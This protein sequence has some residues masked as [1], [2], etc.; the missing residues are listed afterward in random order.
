[1]SL[2]RIMGKPYPQRL[3]P[4]NLARS[5]GTA[6]QFAEKVIFLANPGGMQG[7]KAHH[8]SSIFDTTKSRALIQNISFSAVC[9]VVP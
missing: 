5:H 6:E 9:K 3:K 1:V 4:I 7:L 2:W 8:L